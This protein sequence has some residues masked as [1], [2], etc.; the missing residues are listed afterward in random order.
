MRRNTLERKQTPLSV[1]DRIVFGAIAAAFGCLLG[2]G[3]ALCGF[4]AFDGSPPVRWM[5][6]ASAVYF[7]AV[8]LVRGPEAGFLAGETLGALASVAAVEAGAVPGTFDS[9]QQPESWKSPALLVVWA[10]IMILMAWRL[11]AL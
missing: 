7:F 8:G 10:V 3:A 11:D 9:S 1:W 6:L 2:L 5:V 4:F